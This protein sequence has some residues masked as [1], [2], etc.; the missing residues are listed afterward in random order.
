ME[1]LISSFTPSFSPLFSA[2]VMN[3]EMYAELIG[4][5]E[6]NCMHLEVPSPISGLL[7]TKSSL[8]PELQQNIDA[9]LGFVLVR[10]RGGKRGNGREMDKSYFVAL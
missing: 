7:E 6:I 9:A 10:E 5:F 4:I 3:L 1:R 2:P 8:S